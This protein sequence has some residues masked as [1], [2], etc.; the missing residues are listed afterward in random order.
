M[1]PASSLERVISACPRSARGSRG[2]ASTAGPHLSPAHGPSALAVLDQEVRRP[3][4]ARLGALGGGGARVVLGHVVFEL[5]RV[6]SRRRLPARVLLGRVEVV[7]EVLAVAVADLP[8]GRETR[9]LLRPATVSVEPSR[10][11]TAVEVDRSR[12]NREDLR[13]RRPW[14]RVR[15]RKGRDCSG[16]GT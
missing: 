14:L 6:G 16:G 9:F 4:L 2:G 8:V 10:R 11:R 5:L 3:D 12:G 15:R 1:A 13:V 7:G